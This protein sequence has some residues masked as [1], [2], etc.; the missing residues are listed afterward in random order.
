MGADEG[1]VPELGGTKTVHEFDVGGAAQTAL[2]VDK[3][4]GGPNA[5]FEKKVDEGIRRVGRKGPS[6]IAA[7]D[8]EN[9]GKGRK[10]AE[11]GDLP[12]DEGGVTAVEHVDTKFD[13]IGARGHM[14]EGGG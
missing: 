2:Y 13:G 12:M 1:H 5:G 3:F 10:S 14:V 7:S 11:G 4:A 8:G 6:V 9:T